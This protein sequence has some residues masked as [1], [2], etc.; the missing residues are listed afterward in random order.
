V[1]RRNKGNAPT[2]SW[3]KSGNKKAMG[4]G[5]SFLKPYWRKR[6]K[7]NNEQWLKFPQTNAFLGV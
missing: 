1:S 2:F 4:R 5:S 6:K 7:E 3:R